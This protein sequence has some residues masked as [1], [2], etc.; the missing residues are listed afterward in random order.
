MSV[1]H[2]HPFPS[3]KYVEHP[4]CYWCSRPIRPV[5]F[6]KTWRWSHY[7]GIYECGPITSQG[8]QATPERTQRKLI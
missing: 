8:K 3:Y 1:Y 6:Q 7:S 2:P 5:L 4:I